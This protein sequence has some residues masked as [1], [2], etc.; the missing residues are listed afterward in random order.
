M[1]CT[2]FLLGVLLAL[3][4]V[5]ILIAVFI[6]ISIFVVVLALALIVVIALIL[7]ILHDF[8]PFFPFEIRIYQGEGK[9]SRQQI[10]LLH[11]VGNSAQCG[12]SVYAE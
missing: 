6:L 10:F 5:L 4:L 11:F 1:Q 12:E 7:L 9:Y 8:H 2:A 3:I